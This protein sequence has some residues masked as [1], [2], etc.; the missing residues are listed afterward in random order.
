MEKILKVLNR[1]EE[2]EEGLAGLYRQLSSVFTDNEE[3]HDFFRSLGEEETSHRDL[4]RYQIRLVRNSREP[5][6]DVDVDISCI[7][8]LR[9]KIRK[10]SRQTAPTIEDALRVVL[11]L[12]TSVAEYYVS[13]VIKR[14]NP[15]V[16]DLIDNLSVGCRK[17]LHKCREMA[18]RYRVPLSGPSDEPLKI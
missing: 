9:E 10:F 8:N 6:A 17:H 4:A 14:A 5:F 7:E 12:E 16:S 2:L 18:K 15:E 13:S 11:E 3:M 1:I